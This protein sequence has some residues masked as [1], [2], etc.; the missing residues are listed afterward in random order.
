MD[1]E[2]AAEDF[3][4]ASDELR[5]PVTYLEMANECGISVESLQRAMLEESSQAYVPPPR[6]WKGDLAFLARQRAAELV[7]LADEL[8]ASAW[9]PA[10]EE[11]LEEIGSMILTQFDQLIKPAEGSVHLRERRGD[12][13]EQRPGFEERRADFENRRADIEKRRE[14]RK[15]RRAEELDELNQMFQRGILRGT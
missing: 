7:E 6:F 15:K 12:I 8:E 5:R 3:K 11:E 14:E 9:A 1:L 13:E 2:K 10:T 4:T